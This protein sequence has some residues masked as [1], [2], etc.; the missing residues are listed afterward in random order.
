MYQMY[1]DFEPLSAAISKVKLYN[2]QQTKTKLNLNWFQSS[3][4]SAEYETYSVGFTEASA[5][6]F[7]AME[8]AVAKRNL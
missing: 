4:Q 7:L 8:Q 6:S 1:N 2:L 3:F 5:V